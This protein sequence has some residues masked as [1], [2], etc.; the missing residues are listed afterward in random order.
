MYQEHVKSF[1]KFM[2][3]ELVDEN[4]VETTIED[5]KYLWKNKD[6]GLAVASLSDFH[7]HL[8]VDLVYQL[9]GS[10]LKACDAF[11]GATESFYRQLGIRLKEEYFSKDSEIIRCNDIQKLVYIVKKGRV[12]IMLAKSKLCSLG[13]GGMFGCF[14]KHGKIRQTITAV[15]KV[16][17]AVLTVPSDLLHKVSAFW[18][19]VVAIKRRVLVSN[20]YTVIQIQI[21]LLSVMNLSRRLKVVGFES[22]FQT[23]NIFYTTNKRGCLF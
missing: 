1:E 14:Q 10:T 6:V 20:P 22:E 12:D 5:H 3:D 18:I 13:K 11:A 7:E 4:L 15:A 9:H 21:P 17:V 2:K 16:H 23:E 19:N 8:H